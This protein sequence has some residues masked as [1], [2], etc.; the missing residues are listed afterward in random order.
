L[1]K[2]Q[3]ALVEQCHVVEK[4]KISLQTKFDEEKTQM[5]QEKEQFIVGKLEVK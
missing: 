5:Q 1:K 4:E 2:V 3:G